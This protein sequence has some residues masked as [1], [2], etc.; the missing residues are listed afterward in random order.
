[1]LV[2][3]QW[4]LKKS[5]TFSATLFFTTMLSIV[6]LDMCVFLQPGWWSS[7]RRTKPNHFESHMWKVC[8]LPEPEACFTWW[9]I[10]TSNVAMPGSEAPQSRNVRISQRGL[11][12]FQVSFEAFLI[13]CAAL[14][15]RAWRHASFASR[16]PCFSTVS[17]FPLA[18][19]S[20]ACMEMP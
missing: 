4:E 3:Q 6:I 18:M 7:R 14:Q 20:L 5:N 15:R 17:L 10:V 11:N 8:F 1:M 2:F 16:G 9:A 13:V 19:Q 12:K